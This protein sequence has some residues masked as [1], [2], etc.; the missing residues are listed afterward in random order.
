MSEINPVSRRDLPYAV[1]CAAVTLV[2]LLIVWPWVDVPFNDD[3]SFAFTVQRLL[4]SGRLLYNHWSALPIIS[5]AY[6]G[7][8]WCKVFGFSFTTLRWSMLPIALGCV[9][10]VYGLGRRAGLRAGYAAFAAVLLGTSPLFLPYAASFMTDVP[11]LLFS[12][13]ALYALVAAAESDRDGASLGWVAAGVAVAVVGGVGRQSVFLV[14]LVVL[15]Y[16]LWLKRSRRGVA[17]GVAAA[18]GVVAGVMFFTLRWFAR[19]PHALTDLPLRDD[20]RSGWADPLT[21]FQACLGMGLT[22]ALLALPALLPGR[23]VRTDEAADAPAPPPGI[24]GARLLLAACVVLGTLCL[25][26]TTGPDALAPWMDNTISPAGILATS[27]MYGW[28]PTSLTVNLRLVITAG[29]L[30]VLVID[31]RLLAGPLVQ[32][33]RTLRAVSRWFLDPAGNVV[34]PAYTLFL[35]VYV[36]ALL[37]RCCRHMVYDRYLLPVIPAVVIAACVRQQ[38]AGRATPSPLAWGLLGVFGLFAVVSLQEVTALD[39]VRLADRNLLLGWGITPQQIEMGF[40]FDYWTQLQTTGFIRDVSLRPSEHPP[41]GTPDLHPIVRLE[42][43]S[44][45]YTRRIRDEHYTSWL[46]PFDRTVYLDWV[47]QPK[48]IKPAGAKP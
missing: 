6:W 47:L 10:V 21:P 31:S 27:E 13:G 5:H 22:V 20:V 34:L 8:L 36:A 25:C 18:W 48:V 23:W 38:R 28:R 43:P 17:T 30:V 4:Q 12:L 42:F 41:N 45:P 9:V 37:P 11:G 16:V 26:S 40:E 2:L 1:G 14:P 7:A 44:P 15:P 29:V 39:R 3:W 46:P 19:Q 35:V 33:R 32:P 24:A